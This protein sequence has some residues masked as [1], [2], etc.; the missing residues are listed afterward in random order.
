MK[1]LG[2]IILL[3]SSF[4]YSQSN[5]E[6]DI[7]IALFAWLPEMAL[8]FE[9][10][11]K[12]F[13]D[14]HPKF[15]L[16]IEAIDPYSNDRYGIFNGINNFYD[17][18]IVEIDYY[19]FN[20]LNRINPPSLDSIPEQFV[21]SVDYVGAAAKI[22]DENLSFFVPHW[23]CGNSLVYRSSN[24]KLDK[25][26]SF[27]EIL[28]CLNPKSTPLNVD[29]YGKATL[30]EYYAD[31]VL[32]TY[33]QSE[34]KKHLKNLGINENV[35]LKPDIVKKIKLLFDE[36]NPKFQ[37]KIEQFH[38]FSYLYPE[39]F[40]SNSNSVLLG[41]SERLFYVEKAKKEDELIAWDE[42][43]LNSKEY[44]IK[45]FSFADTSKGTPSWVDGFVIPSGKAKAKKKA[46]VTFLTYI[47]SPNAY[48][49]INKEQSYMPARYLLPAYESAFHE[50]SK[51]SPLILKYLDIQNNMFLINEESIYQG[52]R[53]AGNILSKEL[54][55]N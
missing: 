48:R 15:N 19:R 26:E 12:D 25:A 22:E 17:F 28:E 54:T 31:A 29:F 2:L 40:Y 32:D 11:E 55:N 27:N 16:E 20:D 13:E 49:I 53:K 37:E 36:I 39:D 6:S 38:D 35:S 41:Y 23:I 4:S 42:V 34:A 3:V 9:Q 51:T 14:K 7:K 5:E 30:G 10:I 1:N 33:G 18:D 8:V 50:L 47:I 52:I 44:Q 45:Q 24:K 21:N 43:I 46:I